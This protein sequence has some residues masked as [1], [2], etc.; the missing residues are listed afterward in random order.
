[1]CE[2]CTLHNRSYFM[3]VEK[4]LP[5]L[6]S[7]I[8]SQSWG[9]PEYVFY[10]RSRLLYLA[11]SLKAPS[12]IREFFGTYTGW[13]GHAGNARTPEWSTWMRGKKLVAPP[14]HLQPIEP[15]FKVYYLDIQIESQE[16]PGRSSNVW[17]LQASFPTLSHFPIYLSDL[18]FLGLPYKYASY[19]SLWLWGNLKED[20]AM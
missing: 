17:T 3:D 1:M 6:S 2:L 16:T 19:L 9:S 14:Q 7:Y 18:C 13:V 15:Y 5:V 10:T 11:L 4:I 8:L 20:C 12:A